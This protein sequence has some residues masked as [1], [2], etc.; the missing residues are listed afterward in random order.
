MFDR[1]IGRRLGIRLFVL[2]IALAPLAACSMAG[3]GSSGANS[4]S[5]AEVTDVEAPNAD[6]ALYEARANFRN[7]NF[8]KSAAF[9]KRAVELA[10][11]AVEAYVGLGASYDHL[12]RFDLSDRAY[13]SVLQLG[14]GTAQY[15]N[16]V[17]YSQLLRGNLKEAAANF[18]KAQSLAPGNAVIANNLKLV[19]RAASGRA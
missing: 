17:G 8:G 15:Y 3:L 4:L 9:Y 12:G 11:K 14:G 10:P 5:V 7:Q 13:A 2:T 18:R 6:A 19:A 1:V 16:N